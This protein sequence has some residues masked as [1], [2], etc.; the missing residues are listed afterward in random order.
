MDQS[1]PHLQ[2]PCVEGDEPISVNDGI[3]M[4][5]FPTSMTS[6]MAVVERLNKLGHDLAYI[7]KQDWEVIF[8]LHCV[9]NL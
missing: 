4:A 6:T 2:D 9:I 5:N 1:W 8:K 3:N 7:A